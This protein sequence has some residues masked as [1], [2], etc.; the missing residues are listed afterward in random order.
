MTTFEIEII[1]KGGHAAYPHLCSDVIVT[2]SHIITQLQTIASR[3]TDPMDPVVVSIGAIHAGETHNVLSNRCKML[4]TTRALRLETHEHVKKMITR[5]AESTASGFG[6]AAKVAYVDSYP[7]LV[8]D[9][10]AAKLV[11]SVAGEVV[12]SQNVLAEPAPTLGAE[13]FAFYAQAVP[14]TMWLL[15]LRPPNSVDYAKLHQPNFDFPDSVI[16][17]AVAMHC[18]IAQRFLATGL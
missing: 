1:G 14:S 18:R 16:P 15:G 11:Q 4:G 12:G 9:V 6:V 7:P 5:L 2:A 10:A 17:T 3:L 13:D 8:N